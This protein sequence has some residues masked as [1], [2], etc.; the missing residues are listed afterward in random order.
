ML[1]S[2]LIMAA[3]RT[4]IIN[5]MADVKADIKALNDR[6]KELHSQLP[7]EQEEEQSFITHTEL[8]YISTSGNTNTET[9]NIDAKVKKNW[10]KHA[11]ELSL[12]MQYGSE[13]DIENKNRFLLELGYDYKF[14]K[15]FAFNYLTGY[16]EDKFS[17]YNY[18]FYTGP[19]AKYKA[20]KTDNHNLSLEGNIL[21]SV[22][23]I[24]DTYHDGSGNPVV[25]PY[26]AGSVSNNDGVNDNYISYRAKTVY[27]WQVF[28][29]LKFNQELSY[30]SEFSDAENY[31]VY[32]KTALSSKLS[33][34][35]SAGIGYQV[36]YMNKAAVGKTSTDKT[37]TFNLIVDY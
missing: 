9:F 37:L 12:L 31:F 7:K 25:Y 17:G 20:I 4:Q 19:G 26:P 16:K 27:S 5:E 23:S 1:T 6:L 22:D 35:F 24:E 10:T 14:T 18:Q 30:R 2:S 13:N 36:D 28:N 33:D 32:S 8:G 11:L 3:E 21:Y 29:N 34:I 15:R